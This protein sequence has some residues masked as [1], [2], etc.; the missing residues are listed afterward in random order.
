M[1][2][3]AARV[4]SPHDALSPSGQ[5]RADLVDCAWRWRPFLGR[6]DLDIRAN[7]PHGGGVDPSA[8]PPRSDTRR[9]SG[10]WTFST[11]LEIWVR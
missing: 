11:K 10:E 8:R 1:P 5:L 6:S 3:P 7:G 2:S 9:I 4:L